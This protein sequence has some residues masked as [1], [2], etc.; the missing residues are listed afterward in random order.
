MIVMIIK[1]LELFIHLLYIDEIKIQ[2]HSFIDT[3]TK[4][5]KDLKC[6]IY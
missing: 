5:K 4:Y 2:N 6:E 1:S 3:V